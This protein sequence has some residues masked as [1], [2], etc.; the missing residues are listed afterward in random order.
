[1]RAGVEEQLDSEEGCEGRLEPV[2]DVA[3]VGEGAVGVEDGPGELRL[4]NADCEILGDRGGKGGGGG[5]A[6]SCR[7][8]EREADG[9]RR[10]AQEAE[11]W[12]DI[13]E[14]GICVLGALTARIKTDTEAWNGAELYSL[15]SFI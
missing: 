6:L 5:D 1:M 11:K 14:Q 13:L 7:A 12:L 9:R 8:S 2:E 10:D 3:G 4:R 15:L